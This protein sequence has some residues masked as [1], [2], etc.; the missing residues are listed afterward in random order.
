MAVELGKGI[1][2]VPETARMLML[3]EARVRRWLLGSKNDESALPSPPVY[4]DGV[5]WLTFADLVSA[6]FIDAFRSQGLSLQ[7]IRRMADKAAA[8]YDT[9]RPFSIRSFATDGKR[10][11]EWLGEEPEAK[12]G[13]SRRRNDPRDLVDFETGQAAIK[14]VV[15]PLLRNLDY[16]KATLTAERWWPLGQARGVVVDPEIALGE[17]TIQ[18]IPTRVLHGPK[19]AKETA[20]NVAKW[21]GL[22]RAEVLAAWAYEEKMHARAA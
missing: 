15:K 1:F 5:P 8:R 14:T 2:T 21:Y 7:R 10:I 20:T 16:G 19:A 11:Y 13:K 3:P 9:E 4:V 12:T 22:K 18:G 17:P 6:M